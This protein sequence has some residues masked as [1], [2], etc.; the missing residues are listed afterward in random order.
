VKRLG[1]RENKMAITN[2][3]LEGV[4]IAG[5]LVGSV[6]TGIN[7]AI[8]HYRIYQCEN[9]REQVTSGLIEKGF[10]R[11][12]NEED[13]QRICEQVRNYQKIEKNHSLISRDYSILAVPFFASLVTGALLNRRMKK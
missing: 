12:L 10:S 1:L 7:G 9:E 11:Q 2:R 13:L 8:E 3:L 6:Y 4:L 5:G